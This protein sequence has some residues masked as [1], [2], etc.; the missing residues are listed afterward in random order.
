MFGPSMGY[1]PHNIVNFTGEEVDVDSNPNLKQLP[2]DKPND[3]GEELIQSNLV[4]RGVE[5]AC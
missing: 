3:R 2:R 1:E 5:L 4:V